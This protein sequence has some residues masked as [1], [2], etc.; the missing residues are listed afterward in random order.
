[1]V[2][3]GGGVQRARKYWQPQYCVG[4]RPT[5]KYKMGRKAY[6][7]DGVATRMRLGTHCTATGF[8]GSA[9]Q[10]SSETEFGKLGMD[11]WNAHP[12]LW[13]ASVCVL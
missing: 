4:S 9:Q 6:I 1:M 5:R 8:H 13:L 2:I 10:P 7:A 11:F 12:T 3:V